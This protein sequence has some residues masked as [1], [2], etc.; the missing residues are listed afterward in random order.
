MNAQSLPQPDDPLLTDFEAAAYLDVA[1]HT[2]AVWRS[3]GRYRL[4]FVKVGRLVRYRRSD[5]D[6]FLARRTTG[7]NQVATKRP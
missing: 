6:A 2:L 1:K 7:I 4:P 5:L 3:T